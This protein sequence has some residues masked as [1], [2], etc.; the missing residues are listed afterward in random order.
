MKNF[1][2]SLLVFLGACSYGVVSTEMKIAYKNGFSTGEMLNGQFFFGWWMLLALVILFSKLRVK[3]SFKKLCLLT[4]AGTNIGLANIFFGLS[5]RTLPVSVTVVLLFQFTWM[6]ILI[7][8]VD[9]KELPDVGKVF[10]IILL[11]A[12]TLLAGGILQNRIEGLTVSGIVYG[13]LS[14][15]TYAL[16]I[17]FTGDFASD[18]PA[19][20][21]SF[22]MTT[23]SMVL[24]LLVFTPSFLFN[25]SISHGLW[26][27]GLILG[28]FGVVIPMVF[29]AIGV[30]KTGS[31]LATILGAAELPIAVLASF[32]L[33]KENVTILQC[34]GIIFILLG[35]AV[36]QIK[37][38]FNREAGQQA[39]RGNDDII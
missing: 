27:H 37:M 23:G 10:S 4:V 36:P 16:F 8:A 2:Y 29:Y 1:K 9:K 28:L 6:G 22:F 7:E 5:L 20:W 26:K 25:G 18:I 3:V 21:R 24:L 35:I 15:M 32:L 39:A 31:G 33:L 17:F 11:L 12:G 13:L 30:P 38:G 19:L 14:A 34:L